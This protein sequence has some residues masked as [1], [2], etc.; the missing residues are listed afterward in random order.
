MRTDELDARLVAR[1]LGTGPG[2]RARVAV[3]GVDCSGKTT[4]ADRL[5]DKLRPHRPVVRTSIDDYVLPPM[6]RYRRGRSNP[7]GCYRDTHDLRSFHTDVLDPFAAGGDGRVRLR[8]FYEQREKPEFHEF[9]AS[10]PDALL[11]VDGVFLRRPELAAAW[12]LVVLLEVTDDEVIRRAVSRDSP[13]LGNPAALT[14]L[15]RTRYLPAQQLY[16]ADAEREPDIVIDNL[17]P[18]EPVVIAW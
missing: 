9:R 18:S 3:D 12:D 13:Q 2:R 15:Y 16:G 11:L 5:A 1:L 7:L 6:T 10:Q 4:V 8:G 17:D 14:S